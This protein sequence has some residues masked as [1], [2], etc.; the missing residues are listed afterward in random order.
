MTAG[1]GQSEAP[2]PATRPIP[3]CRVPRLCSPMTGRAAATGER[4]ATGVS[5]GLSALTRGA[6]WALSLAFL[7]VQAIATEGTRQV[8]SC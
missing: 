1:E 8:R 7:S 5:L 2:S 6:L 4:Q 3:H